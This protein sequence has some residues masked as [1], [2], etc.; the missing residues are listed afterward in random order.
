MDEEININ[1]KD[2]VNATL[3]RGIHPLAVA[4]MLYS[5]ATQVIEFFVERAVVDHSPAVMLGPI[6]FGGTV[7][8][9]DGDDIPLCFI[10]LTADPKMIAS[11]LDIDGIGDRIN[12]RRRELGLDEAGAIHIQMR[13]TEE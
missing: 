3:G 6:V 8:S 4:Q 9:E 1:F 7:Q 12:E 11:L 13:E 10:G 5:Q 2:V